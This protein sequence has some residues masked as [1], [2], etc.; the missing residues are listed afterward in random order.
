MSYFLREMKKYPRE[1]HIAIGGQKRSGIV[2]RR[3]PALIQSLELPVDTLVG[4]TFDLATEGAAAEAIL[5]RLLP[6]GEKV[7]TVPSTFLEGC[8]IVTLA[9]CVRPDGRHVVKA[10]FQHLVT[11]EVVFVSACNNFIGE[12]SRVEAREEG[13]YICN[14]DIIAPGRFWINAKAR[15][16]M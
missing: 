6:L 10:C 12:E 13:W 8:R 7:G 4:F 14:A 16:H 1:F 2:R 5:P 3:A 9:E 15:I 11:K